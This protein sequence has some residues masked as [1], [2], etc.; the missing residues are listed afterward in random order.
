[1]LLNLSNHPSA[2]WS[3]EQLQTAIELFG[4]VEDLPFPHIDPKAGKDE[5]KK[6]ASH[7]FNQIKEL[8]E[9]EKLQRA[10]TDDGVFSGES[11]V[12]VHL[13]GELTF[14]FALLKM[15]QSANIKCVA[16][17]TERQVIQEKDGRKTVQFQFVQ[18]REYIG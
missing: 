18:F 17:T 5:I 1:M 2:N 9:T 6:L 4:R 11:K 3:E 14:C 13:M 12:T 7:Y 8:S 16:S 10:Q 15:L